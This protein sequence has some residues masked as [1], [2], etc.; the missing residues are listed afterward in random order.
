MKAPCVSGHGRSPGARPEWTDEHLPDAC[1]KD[2]AAHPQ[3]EV[4][5]KNSLL[6]GIRYAHSF[7]VPSSRPSPALHPESDDFAAMPEVFATGFVVGLLEWACIRAVNPH[8]DWPREQ[9]LGTHIDVSHNAAMPPGLAIVAVVELVAVDGPK[10]TFSVEAHDGID[11]ISKG[12]HERLVVRRERN[13]VV[14]AQH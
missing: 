5:M 1:G 11:L 12:V 13:E 4:C 14:P 7:A 10:L 6:P 9:T 8:I 3:Y 2:S